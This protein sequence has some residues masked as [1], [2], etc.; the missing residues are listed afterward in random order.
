VLTG[1]SS[2][3]DAVHA[4][5][6]QRATFIGHDLRSL[7]ENADALAVAAQSAWHI[8]IGDAAITVSS[9]AD[10]D[11]GD[12]LSIVRAVAHAVWSSGLDAPTVTIKAGDDTARDAL[13]RWSLT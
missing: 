4:V 1:V 3:R 9:A 8:D 10:D 2:A 5:P 7:H 12:G 6:E 11:T 13:Q